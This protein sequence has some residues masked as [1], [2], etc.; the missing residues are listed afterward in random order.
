MS[1]ESYEKSDVR[2]L[3]IILFGVGLAT[4]I[5]LLS[6]TTAWLFNRFAMRE[7]L[8]KPA[9]SPLAVRER[10]EVPAEPR[11]E[12]APT[13]QLL[14]LHAREEQTLS[15]YGWVDRGA[16]VVRIP[17]QRAIDLLAER[18]LPARAAPGSG[19]GDSSQ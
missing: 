11:L 9:L 18:G 2:F 12:V 14:E 17:V 7:S 15:T 3:P 5:A 4:C 6:V 1:S 13:Q 8:L 19:S 16:G 10:P